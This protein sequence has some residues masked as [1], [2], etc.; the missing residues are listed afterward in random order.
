[1]S[2]VEDAVEASARALSES[3]YGE[4]PH[5]SRLADL[6]VT[7]AWPVLSAGLRELHHLH[8]WQSSLPGRWVTVQECDECGG[9]EWP[10]LTVR[11]LDRIDQ[12][13]GL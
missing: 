3:E 8:E 7:A 4:G 10:C 9:T 13:L 11:E 5:D 6:A 2:T 12:E 1:M